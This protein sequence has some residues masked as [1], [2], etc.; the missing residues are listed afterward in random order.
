MY[1]LNISEH[2]SGFLRDSSNTSIPPFPIYP[3]YIRTHSPYTPI[4]EHSHSPSTPIHEPHHIP[5]PRPSTNHTTFPIHVQ[6][7]FNKSITCR[8]LSLSVF[9]RQHIY[10]YIYIYMLY[11]ILYLIYIYIY[12]YQI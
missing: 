2:I 10:I 8:E 11:I 5:H 4:H 12:I 7:P 1:Q 9:R 3:I 6:F